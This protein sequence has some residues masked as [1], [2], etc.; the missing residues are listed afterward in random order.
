M[1]TGGAPAPEAHGPSTSGDAAG[2]FGRDWIFFEL[3]GYDGPL[4]SPPPIAGFNMTR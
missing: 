1:P 4:P 3:D 2:I